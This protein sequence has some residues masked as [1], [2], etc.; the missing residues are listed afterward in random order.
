[1][2]NSTTLHRR[3]DLHPGSLGQ[4]GAGVLA[5]R[6]HLTVHGNRNAARGAGTTLRQIEYIAAA[7]PAGRFSRAGR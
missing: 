5:P 2:R 4:L 3:N 1:M 7:G 6:N